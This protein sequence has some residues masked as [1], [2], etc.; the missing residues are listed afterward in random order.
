VGPPPN[1][2]NFPIE[3]GDQRTYNAVWRD[4]CLWTGSIIVPKAGLDIGQTTAHWWRID[5]TA[6]AALA[7]ADQGD[8]GSEDLGAGTHTF[9][10]QIMVD[11]AKNMAV[12]F[13]AS[14]PGIYCGAY[15]AARLATDAPGTVGSTGV[16]QAGVDYYHRFHGGSRN[17]WGDYSGLALCPVDEATFWIYNEYAGPRG[18]LGIGFNGE[19]DGRFHTS[20]GCFRL[21]SPPLSV[22]I[23]SF[24]ARVRGG[25]VVLSGSFTST[26]EV[27]HVNVYRGVGNAGA[28]VL[29][30]VP[31]RGSEF[32]FVDRE[33]Q[34][35]N[36]Y[37][38]MIGVVDDEGEF[39]SPVERVTVPAATFELSQNQPNP[40]NPS[41]TIAFT[42]ASREHVTL[43]IYDARGMLVTTLVDAVRG[44]GRH[45]VSW[46]G[47]DAN[48]RSI[49]SGTYF[50]RLDA[51]KTSASR[52]MVLL[53]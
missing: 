30:Q 14:N 11:C 9:Y 51:G 49:G 18:T 33:V 19:E 37:R 32:A 2:F 22:A 16:L 26:L 29:A 3:V 31:G 10:P 12:G 44:V 24:A 13:A 45:E 28:E 20:L 53:K 50:Y 23:A 41:T 47:T 21:K 39:F 36:S 7:L 15:Y 43:S 1:L 35:G 4:N 5:T 6:P 42:L 46:D 52:K 17:R 27:R 34:P 48:G 38:Y 40:F 25:D 8:I